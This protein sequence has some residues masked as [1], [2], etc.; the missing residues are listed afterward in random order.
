MAFVGAKNC[1]VKSGDDVFI[2]IKEKAVIWKI[3][4]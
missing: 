3:K 4:K 2:N 1:T